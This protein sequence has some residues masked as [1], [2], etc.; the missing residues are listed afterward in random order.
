MEMNIFQ[1]I[2]FVLWG[3]LWAGYF[4]LDGFDLG[5]GSLFYFLGKNEREKNAIYHAIGPFWDG[6][7]VWL[8]TAGGATF[9][10]FPTAYAIMFSSLYTPLLLLLFS[11]IIR[12]V[13]VEYRNKHES[14]SWQKFWDV[15][16]FIGSVLPPILLG[17]AFAN[18]FKGIPI[19]EKGILQTNL[20][21]LLNFY[22]IL[23]GALFL[24]CFSTHGALWIAF[25]TEGLLSERAAN[26]A[27]KLWA[28]S[29]IL[30]VIFWVVSFVITNI[31]QN[32]MKA[33]ILIIFPL[34]AVLFY[35]LVP[36]F[37]HKKEYLKAWIMSAL[38]IVFFTA[39]GMAGLFPNILPSSINPAYSLTIM[40]SSSSPLTLKIMTIVAVI[41]VPI[42]LAY[43]FWAYKVFSYRITEEK[44]S[45]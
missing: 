27:K 6:N 7:E 36:L 3:V 16:F 18:I 30:V 45:Y 25:K 28:I 20:L 22:G 39:W 9:A 40:N 12:G 24:F 38:T 31:W 23:G 44:I 26:L 37:I 34:F 5:A 13:A 29:L 19:D 8:I 4:A 10:A 41:F 11:L 1:I 14:P 17:V 35:F 32:Y 15:A 2:W 33:P 42:V 21:G 43:T